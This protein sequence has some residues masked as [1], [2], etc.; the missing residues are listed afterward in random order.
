MLVGE[1]MAQN[2]GAG[3]PPPVKDC[4]QQ[5]FGFNAPDSLIKTAEIASDGLMAAV[6]ISAAIF[7]AKDAASAVASYR[8]FAHSVVG[9]LGCLLQMGL[10]TKLDSPDL[11]LN[12]ADLRAA[13]V[14]S[15][16]NSFKKLV[17]AGIET[18]KALALSGLMA[19]DG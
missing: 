18:D 8:H 16:A 9:P 13:D 19:T 5:R 4:A 6:G 2:L 11:S 17:E 3:G 12:F 14:N 1:S 15:R 10:R 7:R